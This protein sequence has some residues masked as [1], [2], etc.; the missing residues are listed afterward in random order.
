[1]QRIVAALRFNSFLTLLSL[2]LAGTL[3]LEAFSY[4]DHA[5]ATA[6]FLSPWYAMV[7]ALLLLCSTISLAH[8]RTLPVGGYTA[9]MAVHGI[10]VAST[11]NDPLLFGGAIFAGIFLDLLYAR[12]FMRHTAWTFKV[13]IFSAAT[14]AI[15]W[16]GYLA[17]LIMLKLPAWTPFFWIG[18]TV[19]A[20]GVG[21]LVS[22]LVAPAEK[23]G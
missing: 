3:A 2:W 4:Y 23:T 15:L 9:M 13:R 1:M 7:Y 10:L 6:M 22:F 12:I 19:L 16:V 21:Y 20:G 8:Q 18:S 11:F 17:M 5:G 14:P